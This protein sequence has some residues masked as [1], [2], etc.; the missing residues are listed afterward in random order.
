M[1]VGNRVVGTPTVSTL[2]GSTEGFADGVGTA[3]KFNRPAGIA[4]DMQGNV[5]VGDQFNHRIR[6]ITPAGEVTTLAG[7]TAGFADG[8]GSAAQFSS[9]FGISTDS[10]GNVYVGDRGNHRIRKITPAGEV[11]TLAGSTRGFADG[12]GSNAM[13]N[14]PAAIEID[15]QGNVYV[16]DRGNHRIRKITPAREVTTLAG[17]GVAGFIDGIGSVAQ[18]N[19]PF[20][21]S[22][23]SQGNVY[24]GDA[25]NHS[26]RKIT[27]AGEVTTL[28]GSTQGFADG[29]GSAAR[30][31]QPV[32]ISTDLQGNVYAA[33]VQNHRIRKITPTGEVTTFAGSGIAGASDGVVS[34]AQFNQPVDVF[35]DSQGNVYVTEFANNRIRKIDNGI[36]YT[37]CFPA[38]TLSAIDNQMVCEG[39]SVSDIAI[40]L[41]GDTDATLTASS[42]NAAIMPTFTF[43]GSGANRTLS[44]ATTAGQVGTTTVTVTA[45][46][47]GGTTTSTFTLTINA[48]PAAPTASAQNFVGTSTV[49][50]LVATGSMG[51]TIK[52]YS[53]STGGAALDP[54][55]VLMTGTYHASQTV[56]GCE[57]ARTAVSVTIATPPTLSVIANQAVCDGQSI[58]NI[59]ITLG[60]DT[61]ATL[62][63]S[64]SNAAITPT[65]TFGGSGANR[66]LSIST[67]LR[68]VGATI[69]TVTATGST[70]AT[71]TTS[72][73]LEVGN[74]TGDVLYIPN[75]GS[76]IVSVINTADN[77]IITNIPVGSFPVG[78][79]VSPAGDRVYITNRSD[80]TV[81]VI[82]TNT[83]SVVST[84]QVGRFPAGIVTSPDGKRVYVA[85]GNAIFVIDAVTN[86]VISEIPSTNPTGISV[87]PNGSRL[88]VTNPV[89]GR[90][91][92]IN[93][94]DNSLIAEIRVGSR[95][96][97]IAIG[98]DG[99]KLYIVDIQPPTVFAINAEDNRVI[100]G[101]SSFFFLFPRAV[102]S[103]PDG[104][105]I[106]VLGGS[107][108]NSRVS[109]VSTFDDTIVDE[110]QVEGSSTGMVISPDGNRLFVT[111]SFTNSV[112]VINLKTNA[113]ENTITGINSP[114]SQFGNFVKTSYTSC[115]EEP[116]LSAIDNQTVCE[117]QSV[118]DIS[119]TLGGDTGAT[120]TASSSNAAITPTFTFGGSG[121]NRTLSI[122]TTAGQVGTTTVTVTATA[123]GGT[124][125]S[126]FTLT[127]NATPAAPTA[128]AQNFVGTATVANLVAT[129][130]MGS[131]I[132]WYSSST[133]VAA[134][135]PSTVLT[136]GTYYASQTVNG[137]ESSRTAV[138]VTIAT[139]PTLSAIANQAVCDGQSISNI[140][141]TLG[142]DIGALLTASSSNEAITPAFTF[143]GSG[144]NRT[145]SISTTLRQVGATT[146]TVTATG[147][148]GS[149][150]TQT[151]VLEV[152]NK[153]V[154]TPTVSTL[155]GST[156][157]FADGI[158]SA[159]QFSSPFGISTD[160]QGNVYV[161][162]RL[163]HRIRKITRVGEVTTLAG[164]STAGF[165]DGVGT[166]ARFFAP[167]GVTV[168]MQGNV[169]V[170][171][172]FHRI[173]KITPSG[174]V[175]TLA[176]S[177]Q[178]FADGIGSAAQL[179]EPYGVA[180]DSQGNI[181]VADLGNQRIRKITPSGEVTTLAGSTRG[182]ADGIGSAA[183]FNLPFGT[184][185]DSQGNVYVADSDNNRIR[186][187]TPT[188]VVTTIAG[189]TAGF[190]DGTGNAAQFSFPFG[191]STDLQGNVYVAD[192]DNHRIRKITPIGEVTTL[193]GSTQGF[194]DGLGTTAQFNSPLGV[195]TD[196]EGNVYV[197]ELNRIRKID[198]GITYTSCFEEP[199]LSAIDNQTVCEGQSVS[200]IAITLG[201]DTGATLT[202]SSSNSAVTPTFT[203]GGSGANRTLSIATT[204]GQVGTT[205]VTVTA[206][207]TGGTTTSTFTLTINATPAA[208][209]ASAQNFV[210]TA[211][212]AN[213][214][215]TGSMG[216]TIKWY[217]S[218][219]GGAALDPSTVLTTGTYY[220]SQTVNGCESARTAV[221]VTVINP[222]VLSAIGNQIVCDGQ[223]IN[224]PVTITG[225]TD[226]LQVGIRSSS[227]PLNITLNGSGSERALSFNTTVGQVGSTI[228]SVTLTNNSGG[229]STQTFLLEVGNRVAGGDILYVPNAN[230]NT[231]S[232]VNTV[233]NSLVTTISV[234][235]FPFGV[236]VSPDGSRVYIT[237]QNDNTVS[238]INTVN[239]TV[240]AT[241]PVERQPQGIVVSPDGSR[242]YVANL[243]SGF[244]SVI[245]ALNNI[246]VSTIPT[247]FPARGVSIS[248]DGSRVYATNEAG[249]AVSVINTDDNTVI[250]SIT[251]GTSPIGITVSPNGNRV[252]VANRSSNTVSVI[253]TV[254]NTVVTTVPVGSLPF[255]VSVS[256]DGSKVYVA[257]ESGRTIS[258]INTI[259]NTLSATISVGIP[260]GVSV[261][262][263]GKRVYSANGGTN[264][265]SV[266]N[267]GTNTIDNTI[268][269]FNSPFSF[270]NFVKTAY[271][272]CFAEPTLSAI[273]NQKVCEG[274]SISDITIRLGGDTDAIL[275]ASSS[276]SAITP[277]FTFGGSGANRTL[278]IA[279]TAGQV[280]TTTVTVTATATGGTTTSTF[281]LTIN[282]IPSAPSASEQSFCGETST[283][284]DLV[285]T[286]ANIQWYLA[287]TGGMALAPTTALMTGT[288]YASQTV[289][290]CESA[291]TAVSV[292]TNSVTSPPIASAQS[293]C[294]SAT[295][296][297]LVATG[298]NIQWYAAEMGGTALAP[299]TVLL[300]GMYYASQTINGCES[301]RTEVSVTINSTTLAPTALAQSFCSTTSTVADLVAT[302]TN[303]QWY[304]AETGGTALVPATVLM[305]G[306]YYVSQTVNGCESERTAVSVTVNAIPAAPSASEQS[307]CGTTST[308]A[309][310]VA[311]GTNIQWYLAETGGTAL[312]PATVLMTGTYYASQTVNSCESE[313]T[314]VSVTINSTT[315]APVAF[316]QSFCGSATVTNL[317]ATGTNIQWYAAEMGGMA[318]VPTTALMTGTYYASQ[319]VNG[320]ESARTAVNVVVTEVP[321][322]LISTTSTSPTTCT[323]TDGSIGFSTN[324]SDGVYVL[325]YQKDG[326][327]AQTATI[328]VASGLFTLS[329]LGSGSYRNF[330]MSEGGCLA[331]VA[332]PIDL[333]SPTVSGGVLMGGGSVVAG[334]NNSTLSL[335]GQTGT[336]LKWQSSTDI[337]FT[338]AQDIAVTTSTYTATNLSE[339][340]Y[341]RVV[342]EGLDCPAVFS[343]VATVTTTANQ[344][345]VAVCR[346]VL[347]EVNTSC[348]VFVN[349][350]EFDGGSFDADGHALTRSISFSGPY[351]VGSHNVE[352]RV[353]DINGAS[354]TCNSLLTVID[355]IVPTV[356]TRPVDLFLDES[357]RAILT[358]D[359]VNAGSF[360]NCEIQSLSLTKTVFTCADLGTQDVF[361]R[362]VDFSGNQTVGRAVIRVF[363]N[364]A[365]RVVAN[366][367]VVYLRTDGTAELDVFAFSRGSSDN[368]G[369]AKIEVNVGLLDC[370]FIGQRPVE[371]TLIDGVGNFSKGTAL[372][373]VLDTIAPVVS[374]KDTVLYLDAMGKASL[375]ADRVAASITESCGIGSISVSRT[376]FDC[377]VSSEMV[378]FTAVDR[379]GNT[380]FALFRVS[381]Q[382]TIAPVLRTRPALV[383]LDSLGV[384]R[385]SIPMIDAGSSDNCELTS[386]TLSNTDFSCSDV[387]DRKVLL[388]GRDAA[389]N[390]S[391]TEVSISVRDSLA[392]IIMARDSIQVFLNAQ[393][394]ASLDVAMIDLGSSDNCGL[395]SQVLSTTSFSCSQVG[396]VRV[397]YKV[398]DVNGNMSDKVIV[399]TVADTLAPILQTQN[400]RI[401]IAEDGRAVLSTSD[402]ITTATDNCSIATQTLSSTVFGCS[403]IGANEV[404][405][406]VVDASGNKTEAKVMVEIVDGNG[407]CPCSYSI[408]ASESVVLKNNR[409]LYG[410]VGTYGVN[411]VVRLENTKVD[412]QRVF[413]R[414][415]KI[416]V[417]AMS[418]P[419]RM[420]ENR[421]PQPFS[422]EQMS[423]NSSQKL[424]VKRNTEQTSSEGQFGV[425]LVN[426]GGKL[427]LTEGRVIA[428]RITIEK[429]GQ[430]IF[431][432]A[433]TVGVIG[434]FK[435]ESDVVINGSNEAVRMYVGKDLVIGSNNQLRGYFHTLQEA[436]FKQSRGTDTTR[437]FGT[438]VGNTVRAL[439][440]VVWDGGV[441]GCGD[442][443]T[444]SSQA[445]NTKAE[446]LAAQ[447]GNEELGELVEAQL[448]EEGESKL[449]MYGP[450]PTSSYIVLN[451]NQVPSVK[452]RLSVLRNSTQQVTDL[453][454][455][456]WLSERVLK[457]DLGELTAGMYLI[458]V[459]VDGLVQTVKIVK[460]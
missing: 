69:V 147:S 452:P 213:L 276:N 112:S 32:G 165:T 450:N 454:T 20:G 30:F 255:G 98:L 310:L 322:T 286:G 328:T 107:S 380:G 354:S 319:T 436:D 301:E 366:N 344:A 221:S 100:T 64:S 284:A 192:R 360:D 173:R 123:T 269:G 97:G 40:T 409:L 182:F 164:S 257:N 212:V 382:D 27:P 417:D 4:V 120:L 55:T 315:S 392:P 377:S 7:S 395:A 331:T 308:V 444:D 314:A 157:G 113:V 103:S 160:S 124:A 144:A 81:S 146:V 89:I 195:A 50:N 14:D 335:S 42:S 35:T 368:C 12:M 216:S 408:L 280:G 243:L 424:R 47:T 434:Q 312:V 440:Q 74:R 423:T 101:S 324:L 118:S 358:V 143:G 68:Q 126:T 451:F 169:Y 419:N 5:Y 17:S 62:T 86:E 197:A 296:A 273:D 320:C 370:S 128:S 177:T 431:T 41:G 1:E 185:T 161:S 249:G 270:G 271:T 260:Y 79:S 198:N 281:T 425:I 242:V 342:V 381:V 404:S 229:S 80:N 218:S 45:T 63:A 214:V 67:T 258:V 226:G 421:V 442:D 19:F 76:G 343:S 427:T 289:N 433:A 84:I 302:G 72:F 46:A 245:D 178:G 159:A 386:L 405:V 264:T 175:T 438:V 162:D 333:S 375:P 115:F 189:S 261:S 445:I 234:G 239:N 291:R 394:T 44:I 251:V 288:Y 435:T 191:I 85:G 82:N 163:N 236:S 407:V 244:I 71:T 193:A 211:T 56:N 432:K 83:N 122:A 149:T 307:F 180:S 303:I 187:I 357:G 199:T 416:E 22:T 241:V 256:P 90:V 248:P 156:E 393:G 52:W 412:K 372:M 449:Y 235:K 430:L 176:G 439:G 447:K 51:S 166:A 455:Q 390:V 384:G 26:V 154:G 151:F 215:A 2:A 18:F 345:P 219:T 254:D 402:V 326:Q 220:A 297:N 232:V 374:V 356:F 152:G 95:P 323:A 341:Y 125:T 448:L 202:A 406:T 282:A 134:L 108:S 167:S 91:S 181:Y 135:D 57:S 346:E 371:V 422:F 190:A 396:V 259:D 299:A 387:G 29:I 200:D 348:E 16:A 413:I 65:F 240:V 325:S 233:D 298:T 136:T 203:F 397:D 59:A 353:T 66:T 172:Q 3:A 102:V 225:N 92:V 272:S 60:G 329:G 279:T 456:T 351:R 376:D 73:V 208:P 114:T 188:G 285:A 37:T 111:N 58:S 49:A 263:D 459:R 171:D 133:G 131:T 43:G 347:R 311:T 340:T 9:P 415:G 10:Q 418:R 460:E 21:I 179:S 277:T 268:T 48:T 206:T 31:S 129:G 383:Y 339:T 109:V 140:A 77:S 350:E 400:A 294:G 274:Q 96:T 278:S 24:V 150:T 316:A 336:I 39:Q 437:V 399:V 23:D 139:P 330:E 410:G 183:Q 217:S 306:T 119:I 247:Q 267:S 13:F 287:E 369:I 170:S 117:G 309:D 53:S 228:V 414:S 364:R 426:R 153:V 292:T 443:E 224:I 428:E 121:A 210:S 252:Y 94:L 283:V 262:A 265:I 34:A 106:Y 429:G 253:S 441:I 349:A 99:R 401:I 105:K 25:G 184:S 61:G 398:T 168:D 238:V 87:S 142:G 275:T 337:D 196:I 317:V 327:P 367:T 378:R 458:T 318:L 359:Q 338:S 207:A 137:C 209:T 88:Y 300:T 304:L 411:K 305:T 158:G 237:N 385:L 33:D 186:K 8:T 138:S 174:E 266:I 313:R 246:V 250:S 365:P 446:Y 379:Q 54:S 127:I 389:G 227:L 38:P 116:T 130:S 6:K 453:V 388:T 148:T 355:K 36:T 230:A 362:A 75:G 290:E 373:T 11:T 205:T 70:G 334:I 223:M 293:F 194:A 363:D 361:L 28:A 295:V 204:A 352:F 155:A 145:L 78:V 93:T 201:G 222:I 110:I 231:V 104:S 457:L 332:G 403:L 141:I 321:L 132:K 15:V 391:S 420:I